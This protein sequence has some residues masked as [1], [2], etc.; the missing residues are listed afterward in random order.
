MR[1][2]P[3]SSTD[4]RRE[5]NDAAVEREG[6]SFNVEAGPV[7]VREGDADV[8]PGPSYLPSPVSNSRTVYA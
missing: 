7:F 4:W 1:G 2:G 8:A 6:M 5:Q 3:S